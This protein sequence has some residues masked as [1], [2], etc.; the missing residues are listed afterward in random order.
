[1]TKVF[2][3]TVEAIQGVKQLYGVVP[4]VQLQVYDR[5]KRCSLPLN[6]VVAACFEH[7]DGGK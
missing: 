6:H 7:S 5:R 3:Q 4:T 2:K 1:M